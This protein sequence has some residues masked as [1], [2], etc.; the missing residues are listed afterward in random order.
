MQLAY[1]RLRLNITASTH[2]S[3]KKHDEPAYNNGLC[4]NLYASS[5]NQFVLLKEGKTP[6]APCESILHYLCQGGIYTAGYR[7]DAL[8]TGPN[9]TDQSLKERLCLQNEAAG[10][11]WWQATVILAFQVDF[12][13]SALSA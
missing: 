6:L 8:V 3:W 4:S 5:N 12:C 13:E 1:T 2:L 9:T 11:V 7:S 10:Q